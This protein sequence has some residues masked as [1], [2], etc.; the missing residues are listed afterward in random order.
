MADKKFE[1]PGDRTWEFFQKTR[2]A[3]FKSLDSLLKTIILVN[4]G[5]AVAVLGFVGTLAAQNKVQLGQLSSVANAIVIF[6]FG[7]VAA[8]CAMLCNYG[9][10]Y[11]TTMHAQPWSAQSW[12]RA[13]KRTCEFTALATTVASIALFIIGAFAVR[14]AIV[15]L[16]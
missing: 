16:V 13:L 9:M 15:R 10:L 4:G 1:P 6:A 8:I 11:A 5:S 3:T 14:N 7:V 2:E 12:W